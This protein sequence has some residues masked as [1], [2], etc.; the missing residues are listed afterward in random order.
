ML[1]F[2]LHPTPQ[3]STALGKRFEEKS[4]PLT[5][6]R[7]AK[8]RYISWPAGKVRGGQ[9]KI[10]IRTPPTHSLFFLLPNLGFGFLGCSTGYLRP[11]P[12]RDFCNPTVHADS[13]RPVGP[14]TVSGRG[15]PVPKSKSRLRRAPGPTCFC[16][17]LS[18]R[19]G[20]AACGRSQ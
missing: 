1:A 10:H 8:G 13:D 4:F 18:P 3:L 9:E 6:C 19:C 2:N 11:L 12:R 17:G 5:R 7:E 15:I 14:T 20:L 16:A